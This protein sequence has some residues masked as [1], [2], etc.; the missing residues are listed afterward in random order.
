MKPAILKLPSKSDQG[1]TLLELLIA[2]VISLSIGSAAG[3]LLLSQIRSSERAEAMEQQRNDWARTTNFIEAEVALSEK[4]YAH[5]APFTGSLTVSAPTECN[6]SNKEARLLLDLRRDLPPIIYSV[7][8]STNGWLGDYSLWRCG[9][10]IDQYGAFCTRDDINDSTSFCS[11]LPYVSSSLL[12]DGLSGDQKNG[13][14][15]IAHGSP[16]AGSVGD[17]KYVRFT[18]SLK[19]HSSITYRQSDAARARISPLYSRPTENSLCGAANMVKLRGT[20]NVADDNDTLEIPNQNLANQDILICGFGLGTRARGLDG[21]TI[22]GG[23]DTND[24]IEA[25]DYGKARL[26][27]LGGNDFLRG[28][29]E[30]DTLIGGSGDDTLVGR[31]QNDVLNGGGGQNTYLPGRGGDT[32]NGGSG[33]DIVFFSVKRSN[34]SLDSAC[35]TTSC[36]VSESRASGSDEENKLSNVEILIFQDARV[37]LED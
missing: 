24:I 34:Y 31:E 16:S 1:F 9:P 25:G 27:G 6:L 21:D 13:F 28:T 32:V 2:V 7:K 11:D 12:L 15:F 17:N 10:S 20:S 26:D 18:L 5:E 23:N 8:K 19:G 37:D 14:G 4:V 30:A 29:R 3:S 33:L 35:S 36:T 22:S